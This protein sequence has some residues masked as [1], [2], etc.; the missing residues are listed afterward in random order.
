MQRI[1]VEF[2]VQKKTATA[3]SDGKRLVQLDPLPA[4]TE[5]PQN[6]SYGHIII[7]LIGL[8]C[9][10]ENRWTMT[11]VAVVSSLRWVA[12]ERVGAGRTTL[13]RGILA[14]RL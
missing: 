5:P 2:A 13:R 8:F 11:P 10:S 6:R 14:C 9:S 7:P 4:S 3:D 1:A 12:L